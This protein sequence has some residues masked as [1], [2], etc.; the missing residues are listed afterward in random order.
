MTLKMLLEI[1]SGSLQNSN[2]W[3][4]CSRRGH[5]TATFIRKQSFCSLVQALEVYHA[6]MFGGRDKH[7]DERLKDIFERHNAEA[8]K[9]FPRIGELPE[10]IRYTRNHQ[11]I[12]AKIPIRRNT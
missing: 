5:S 10:K 4:I 3:L 8:R 1:G 9:L 12:T 6:R 2:R 11:R 7:L